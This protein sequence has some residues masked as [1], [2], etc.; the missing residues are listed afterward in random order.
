MN[1]I[2]DIQYQINLQIIKKCD[3]SY[4][5]YNKTLYSDNIVQLTH[6]NYQYVTQA[7]GEVI[8]DHIRLASSFS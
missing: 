6:N 5:T 4:Y 3:S 2:V 8:F 1:K 7:W